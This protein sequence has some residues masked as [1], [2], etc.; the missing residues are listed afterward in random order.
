MSIREIRTEDDLE[1]LIDDCLSNPMILDDEM[2]DT[3]KYRL[4]PI[5]IRITGTDYSSSIG[6]SVMEPLMRYQQ[7]IYDMIK[8]I[9]YDSLKTKLSQEDK[10]GFE[11]HVEVREGSNLINIEMNDILQKALDMMNGEQIKA[12]LITGMITAGL[13]GMFKVSMSYHIKHKNKIAE[14][15]RILKAQEQSNA[16][17]KAIAEKALSTLES[18]SKMMTDTVKISINAMQNLSYTKGDIEIDGRP[19]SKAELSY[20]AYAKNNMLKEEEKLKS[21]ECAHETSLREVKGRFRITSIEIPIENREDVKHVSKIC[22]SLAEVGEK[23]SYRNF[24]NVKISDSN[25]TDDQKQLL[26]KSLDGKIFELEMICAFDEKEN[27]TEAYI[28]SCDGKRFKDM[29]DD[30]S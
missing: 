28:Q 21:E 22:I 7:K 29:I 9:K 20:A 4:E 13:Y 26:M 18:V 1:K 2:L 3:I 16:T 11:L 10:V 8:L 15:E 27:M 5:R 14:N 19:I 23:E 24:R 17:G 6:T 30:I 25:I 12:V